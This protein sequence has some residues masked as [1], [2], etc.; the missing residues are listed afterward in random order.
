[1]VFT[2]LMAY[3]CYG[4]KGGTDTKDALSNLQREGAQTGPR[5]TREWGAAEAW[6]W[7]GIWSHAIWGIPSLV[8]SSYIQHSHSSRFLLP[9]LCAVPLMHLFVNQ[10]RERA[11]VLPYLHT[12]PFLQNQ[13]HERG[14]APPSSPSYTNQEMRK[15]HSFPHKVVQRRGPS[16]PVCAQSSLPHLHASMAFHSNNSYHV[17]T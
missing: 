9:C 6:K 8:R 5:A 4:W 1:M 11:F 14:C 3:D 12:L 17:F 7:D 2:S 10:D 16:L 13:G 15:A